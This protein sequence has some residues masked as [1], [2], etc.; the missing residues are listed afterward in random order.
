[1]LIDPSENQF[2]KRMCRTLNRDEDLPPFPVDDQVLSAVKVRV[3][4]ARQLDKLLLASKKEEVEKNWFKKAAKE[5]DLEYSDDSAND[6]ENEFTQ[7]RSRQKANQ[8]SKINAKKSELS[9][10]LALPLHQSGTYHGKYP[11]MSGKLQLPSEFKTTGSVGEKSAVKA[12][13]ANKAEMKNLFK[14]STGN[15]SNDKKGLMLRKKKQGRNTKK[16]K[17]KKG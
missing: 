3:N 10:L 8:K 16:K 14:N 11:T 6:S 12:V 2:Y 13:V 17:A 1:M 9:Q 5:A 4:T 15:I 7:A